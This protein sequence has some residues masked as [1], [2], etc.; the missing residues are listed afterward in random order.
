MPTNQPGLRDLKDWLGLPPE[1]EGDDLVLQRA[2]DS[3]LQA[4]ARVVRF[5][6]CDEFQ[7]PTFTDDLITAVFIR[8][9][10]TVARRNSPTGLE[11]ITGTEGDLVA[12]RVPVSDADVARLESPYVAIVSA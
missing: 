12:A 3:A 9:T 7:E 5:Y 4:Q 2:L 1:D 6:P 11:G 8:A 10:R